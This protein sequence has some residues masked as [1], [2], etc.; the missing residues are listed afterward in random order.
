VDERDR[1]LEE[2]GRERRT[3]WRNE[4]LLYAA[5]LVA[6]LAATGFLER[7]S[8]NALGGD[9]P[10]VVKVLLFLLAALVVGMPVVVAILV[11][12]RIISSLR[13]RFGPRPE[14]RPPEPFF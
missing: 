9:K 8:S 6:T 2:L 10:L 12:G 11:L 14:D 1:F 13:E 5:V 7:V 3:A 4:S